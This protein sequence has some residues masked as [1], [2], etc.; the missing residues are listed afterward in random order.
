MD[1]KTKE[2]KKKRKTKLKIE[3]PQ[4]PTISLL[5]KHPKDSISYRRNNYISM[6]ID[7]VCIIPRR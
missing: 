2:K 6:F 1:L 7:V 5:D 4:D 3:L